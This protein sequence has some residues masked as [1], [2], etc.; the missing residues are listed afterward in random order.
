MSMDELPKPSC[1]EFRSP[2]QSPVI[3]LVETEPHRI[4]E[5]PFEVIEQGPHKVT[6]DVRSFSASHEKG[7]ARHMKERL[8]IIL[9]HVDV[10]KILHD[11]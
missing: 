9:K 2:L 5:L 3:D 7:E 10:A 8:L 11:C 4:S 1:G 6:P